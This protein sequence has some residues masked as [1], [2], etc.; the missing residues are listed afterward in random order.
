M[1]RRESFEVDGYSHGANPIPAVSRIG[2]IVMTGGISGVNVDT[3]K[4]PTSIEEQ[5]A[6]MFEL[7]AKVIAAAGARFEDVI[8]VTV[9]LRPDLNRDA[10]NKEWL[11]CFPDPHSR[12]ARHVIVNPHLVAGMLVQSEMMVVLA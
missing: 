10:L 1:A 3:G 11:R 12:P 2:K 4:M 9:Y 6:N 8:K 7:A 5:C